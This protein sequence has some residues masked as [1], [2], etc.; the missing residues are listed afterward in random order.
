MNNATFQ[1]SL[2]REPALGQEGGRA[3]ANVVRT[4]PTVYGRLVAGPDGLTIGK[5]AWVNDRVAENST[6][7][8]T[9]PAGFAEAVNNSWILNYIDSVSMV[10]PPGYECSL[11][12]EGDFYCI[13]SNDITAGMKAFASTTD[14]SIQG[15]A[16]GAT[17]AG[18]VETWFVFPYAVKAKSLAMISSTV[19]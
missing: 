19:K 6:S 17:I 5:F 8:T 3:S 7:D 14:G 4:Y 9:K 10:V 13:P 16:E 2:Q 11:A 12:V 15:G 18:Y 1:T